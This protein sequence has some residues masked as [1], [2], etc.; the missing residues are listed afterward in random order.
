[1]ASFKSIER[2]KTMPFDALTN[3]DN[4]R[5][6]GSMTVINDPLGNAG[7]ANFGGTVTVSGT[8]SFASSMNASAASIAN[9]LTGSAASFAG[10]LTASSISAGGLNSSFTSGLTVSGGLQYDLVSGSANAPTTASSQSLS[11]ASGVIT[12]TSGIT[13]GTGPH[14]IY[15]SANT[16]TV[17]AVT[18]TPTASASTS[19]AF[20]N[21]VEITVVN[22]AASGSRVNI[23]TPGSLTTDA[24]LISGGHAVKFVY[25][26]SAQTWIPLVN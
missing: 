7:N 25:V 2:E 6:Q 15:V 26:A 8:A 22:L 24:I 3:P 21:G 11:A 9:S 17:S 23:T 20:Q 13:S 5:I 18:L 16:T 12:M 14:V 4:F 19:G 1:V 10:A